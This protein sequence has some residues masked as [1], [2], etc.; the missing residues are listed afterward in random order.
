M[1]KNIVFINS[2][3]AF[4]DLEVPIN[5]FP[6]ESRMVLVYQDGDDFSD[7]E[8][9]LN[10]FFLSLVPETNEKLKITII[11]PTLMKQEI[12]DLTF[13]K[14]LVILL[15]VVTQFLFFFTNNAIE[16]ET[17]E[18]L[19]EIYT[20]DKIL[21]SQLNFIYSKNVDEK[22][23]YYFDHIDELFRQGLELDLE[24]KTGLVSKFQVFIQQLYSKLI[25][26]NLTRFVN[27]NKSFIIEEMMTSFQVPAKKSTF[28]KSRKVLSEAKIIELFNHNFQGV[29]PKLISLKA[30]E[31]DYYRR[32][33]YYTFLPQF[34]N[35]SYSTNPEKFESILLMF[36]RVL[37]HSKHYLNLDLLNNLHS[38]YSISYRDEY[39]S[40][41]CISYY[42]DND[43][44]GADKFKD[45]IHFNIG[46]NNLYISVPFL[47][48]LPQKKLFDELSF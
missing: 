32:S 46:L 28:L 11:S 18:L 34:E 22:F 16:K 20:M 25:D 4:M 26:E 15:P 7:A 48:D 29:L 43:I 35:S 47:R 23:Y 14:K 8:T 21:P 44:P 41:F 40:I 9:L 1:N 36:E 13:L 5:K 12:H 17:F 38:K 24:N 33:F 10:D 39:F 19:D 3:K 45:T 2:K 30:Q 27:I 31:K 42:G 6:N 37:N